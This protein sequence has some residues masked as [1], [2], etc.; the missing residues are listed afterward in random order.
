PSQGL[1]ATPSDGPSS[2]HRPACG[3]VSRPVTP[4]RC[5]DGESRDPE[6]RRE[7]RRAIGEARGRASHDARRGVMRATTAL[8]LLLLTET[9][10]TGAAAPPAG[11]LTV[12]LSSFATEVLDPDLGGH[13]VKSYLALISDYLTAVTP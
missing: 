8:L 3:E 10:A 9:E 1:D 6:S 7:R 4:R 13:G 2:R 5:G 11:E 12:A